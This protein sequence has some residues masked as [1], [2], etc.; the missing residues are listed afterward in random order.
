MDWR[1][2][3]LAKERGVRCAINPDAHRVEGFADLWYGVGQ[4]RK[5][6]LERDD[7]LNCLPRAEVETALRVKRAAGG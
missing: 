7:V 3:K 1:W 2:W 5:G 6:W 4:A